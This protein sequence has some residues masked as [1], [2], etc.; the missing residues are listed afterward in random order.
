MV[1]DEDVGII[2]AKK[3]LLGRVWIDIE[4]KIEQ[5]ASPVDGSMCSV[6]ISKKP[7]WYDLIFDATNSK[8][9]KILVGYDIIPLNM[10]DMFPLDKRNIKPKTIPAVLSLA[11]IGL[12]DIVASLDLFPV[13]KISCK[14]DISGDSAEPITTGKHPVK[15]GSSNIFEIQT[16]DLEVPLDIQFSPVLTVY[17]Y[18]N[19]M[20]F[21]G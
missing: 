12:R 16:I 11:C 17:I 3:D 20:G 10:K 7:Q 18:D 8:D 13:K 2:G 6:T 4:Q 15:G 9:G 21:L 19:L 1:Y 14:F 5:L